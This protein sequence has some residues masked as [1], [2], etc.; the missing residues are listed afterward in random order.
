[1]TYVTYMTDPHKAHVS[2][3]SHPIASVPALQVAAGA[4]KTDVSRENE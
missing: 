3:R 1:M 4:K 2:L